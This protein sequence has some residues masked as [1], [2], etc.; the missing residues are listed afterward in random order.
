MA[1]GKYE[2]S[3]TSKKETSNKSGKSA[4]RTSRFKNKLTGLRQ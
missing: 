4:E 2:D 3:I 1:N